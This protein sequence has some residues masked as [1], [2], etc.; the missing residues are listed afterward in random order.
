MPC[1]SL[2][3]PMKYTDLKIQTQREA[4]NNARTEGFAL[5]VRAG[6]MTRESEILPLGKEA[7]TRLET[8]S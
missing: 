7:L 6:Y 4:P 3:N 2:V 8:L 5:L 1:P